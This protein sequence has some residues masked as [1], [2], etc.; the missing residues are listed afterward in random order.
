MQ[1]DSHPKQF[2]ELFPVETTK[3][4]IIPE[5]QRRYSWKNEQIEQLFN[6]IWEEDEGYYIGNLLVTN[7]PEDKDRP[8][9]ID[10]QQR[11]ITTSLLLLGI[12]NKLE[13]MW[14]QLSALS[15]EAQSSDEEQTLNVS[16]DIKKIG[17][18]QDYI[19]HRLYIFEACVVFVG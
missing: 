8:D 10:G 17:K 6:D 18:I 11:L 14:R 5:Y 13:I 12:W 2:A 4:F 3:G 9:V 19:L 1:I 15:A 16:K 7:D